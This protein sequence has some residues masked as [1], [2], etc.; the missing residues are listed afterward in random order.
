MITDKCI[1]LVVSCSGWQIA[2]DVVDQLFAKDLIANVEFLPVYH[3]SGWKHTN[4]ETS[5]VHLILQTLPH[6]QQLVLD[7]IATI[8]QSQPVKYHTTPN[9]HVSPAA[10][11][12]LERAFNANEA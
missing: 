6:K 12:W 9:T 4:K 10:A 7:V 5:A 8:H 1:E 3:H 2:Q 11:M